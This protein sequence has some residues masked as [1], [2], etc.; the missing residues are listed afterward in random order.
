M[1]DSL[2]EPL[3]RA[4]STSGIDLAVVLREIRGQPPGRTDESAPVLVSDY[5]RLLG[6]LADL[7][8]EETVRMSRRPLMPGAFHFGM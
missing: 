8:S 1:D 2:F 5:F 3:S 6:K 7:T 4:A